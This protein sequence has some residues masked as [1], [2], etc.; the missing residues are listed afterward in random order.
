MHHKYDIR[1]KDAFYIIDLGAGI[2]F[3]NFAS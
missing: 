2:F 1:L 3:E